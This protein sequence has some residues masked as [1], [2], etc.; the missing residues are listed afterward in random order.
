MNSIWTRI[1]VAGALSATVGVFGC[2]RS[3]LG[4]GESCE[5]GDEHVCQCPDGSIGV[6]ICGEDGWGECQCG[7]TD[8]DTDSDIDADT[9]TDSDTDS[10]TDTD[11][12]TDSDTDTDTDT[13]TDTETGSDTDT[14]TDTS[15]IPQSYQ[16]CGSGGDVHWFDSCDNEGAVV[17]DCADVNGMCENLTPTTAQC[18]CVTH[19]LGASCSYC[20]PY[21][22]PAANCDD[23]LPHWDILTDCVTCLG[24][25]DISTG[26]TSC[27]G[28]WDP[29]ADCSACLGNWD[30]ATG[31]ST[32]ENHWVDM[33][34]DCGTCP[35]HWDAAADCDACLGNW[36]IATGC[37]TCENHWV[38][39]GDDCGTCPDNWDATADCNACENHWVDMGDDCGTCPPHWDPLADCNACEGNWDPSANCLYCLAHWDISDNCNSCLGNWD[40][41]TNCLACLNY[42]VDEGNDCGTCLIIDTCVPEMPSCMAAMASESPGYCNGDDDDCDGQVDEGCV[43]TVGQVQP[44]FLGPPNFRD[45]GTCTDGSQLCQSSGG[46]GV[47]GPCE[48]GIWPQ[49]EQC[50]DADNNCNGCDDEG[51]CC[52]PW[53][54]CSYDPGTVQPFA[55]LDIDGMD[56]YLGYG[57]TMWTWEMSAGPCGDV[58]GNPPFTMNGVVTTT[59]SGPSVD[60]LTLNFS[61][62]GDYELV[63]TVDTPAGELSC[64]W[65][66]HVQAPGLR[67]ELCWG[68]TGSADV[69]LHLGK[70]AATS[71]WFNQWP[72]T[73]ADCFYA[74]CK[75]SS[76]NRP[77]WGYPD[78][79][80]DPNPRLD[81]DNISTVGV[82]E[83]I[84]LDNPDDG[85]QFRVLV[86]FYSGPT[87]VTYPLVNVYCDGARLATYGEVPQVVGFAE[88]WKVVDVTTNVSSTGDLTCVLDPVLDTTGNY[89]L[90]DDSPTWP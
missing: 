86:H 46:F 56:I 17:D 78:V 21:W 8:T 84:N 31:C 63:L 12:D 39:M 77:D 48:G 59:L 11:T 75:V 62:S 30:I 9:D 40:P 5:V 3:M 88:T 19:W 2:G 38:D 32:C 43:C 1:L 7:S 66:I 81:L 20:P 51:M 67:V 89:V 71:D 85:D 15:C 76:W 44:C 27:L 29:A 37:S 16:Q 36:D 49:G 87:P 60:F 23:C 74:N 26:C 45:H 72:D 73:E 35:P 64:T 22:D 33:G 70:I 90:D 79:L 14:V 28:N 24:N 55:D 25:W 52:D 68:T 47:W 57:A 10:D 4:F 13:V 69:D 82:P 54:L 50:D 58:L 83:N 41:A 65:I 53:I 18:G 34:D 42:W 6:Q 80:G 61:L